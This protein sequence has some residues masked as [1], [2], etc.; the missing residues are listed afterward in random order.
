TARPV[1]G[2]MG[3]ALRRPGGRRAVSAL[4]ALLCL[5][6]VSIFAF[7]AVTDFIGAQHQRHVSINLNSPQFRA[8]YL[9]GAVRVG[10][11]LTKLV[12]NNPRVQVNVVVVEGTSVAALQAGAGHYPETPYPCAAGNVAIAGHRT[13]YGRPFN[14][15]NDMKAGDLVT[16][17]T[18]IGN[19]TYQVVPPFAGHK[20]PWIVSPDD[21]SVVS[22]AGLANGHWLT[23]TSCNPPGSATQRIVLRLKMVS[24][25]VQVA[26]TNPNAGGSGPSSVEGGN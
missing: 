20:N 24:S 10:Q 4:T 3:L 19:C 12:I 5:G 26:P 11:G 7:P 9:N 2:L 22:Q 1:G 17:Y 13:T 16:L 14:R 8:E 25:T 6:G 23:L 18:P 15:I 21:A